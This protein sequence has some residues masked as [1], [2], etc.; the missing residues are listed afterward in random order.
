MLT[1]NMIGMALFIFGATPFL[2][3]II[4]TTIYPSTDIHVIACLVVGA[5]LLIAFAAW[6]NIGSRRG[7][8]KHPLTPTYV[9]TAGYGRDLT[10]PCIALA[11]INMFYY[12]SSILWPTMINVF[13][14]DDPTDWKAASLLSVVQGLAILAGVL[15]LSFFGSSIKR[16]N[17]QLSGYTF[18]MVVFGVLLALGNPDRKGMMI[19]FVFV[20][21]AAYG[22]SI[23]LCIAVSQMGVEQKDLGL[24]GGVSGTSRFAGGAIATA[25]YT[26]VLTNTVSKWSGKLI[27]A[28]A[29]AAGLPSSDVSSLMGAL[30]TPALAANYSS[31]VVAAVGKATQG[32]Y[33]HGIQ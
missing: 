9:F 20:S 16:W 15:F 4:Y 30:G 19:A 17:W 29:V 10:A 33:E 8:L 31:E 21:Q 11:V 13:Y 18:L 26:A 32:A 25:V 23:Y 6:E 2:A 22:A 5:V 24:S 7:F 1:W 28:A 3:G 14:L 27:P 12:S